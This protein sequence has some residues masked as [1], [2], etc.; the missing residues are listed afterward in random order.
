MD[1]LRGRVRLLD[2]A[3]DRPHLDPITRSGRTPVIRVRGRSRRRISS[4][5]LTCYEP[6]EWSRLVYRP[7]SDDGRRDGRKSFAWTDYR[8]LLSSPPISS[9]IVLV[10]DNVNVHLAAGMRQFIVGRGWPTVYQ[11]PF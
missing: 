4:A 9:S 2:D 11:L 3:T 1:R 5:A 10:S 8:D 7:R 6:G